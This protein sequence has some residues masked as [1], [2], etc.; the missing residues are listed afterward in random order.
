MLG[1]DEAN[2]K[3][4]P[5]KEALKD[6]ARI[7]YHHKHLLALLSAIRSVRA[8]S[9]LKLCQQASEANLIYSLG[10]I[11]SD[12]DLYNNIYKSLIQNQVTYF[13]TEGMSTVY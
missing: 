8:L 11:T 5:L 6:D 7:E 10:P 12:L 1:V 3:S 13:R 4:L 2:N 9:T